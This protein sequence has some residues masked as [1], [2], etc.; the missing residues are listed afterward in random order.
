VLHSVPNAVLLVAESSGDVSLTGVA[1]RI[2]AGVGFTTAVGSLGFGAALLFGAFPELGWQPYAGPLMAVSVP[3]LFAALV[4]LL[5]Y[6][7][8]R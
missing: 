5:P 7:N 8:E 3:A 6:S 4:D 1:R 2:S